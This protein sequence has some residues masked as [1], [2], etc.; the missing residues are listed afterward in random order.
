MSVTVLYDGITLAEAVDVKV[1]ELGVFLPLAAPMP[2]G[3][4]L[5]LDKAG[6]GRQSIRVRKVTE[7]GPEPG[8]YIAAEGALVFPLVEDTDAPPDLAPERTV[9][10]VS[11]SQLRREATRPEWPGPVPP[12]TLASADGDGAPIPAGAD[13]DEDTLI[14]P[15]GP[16]LLDGDTRSGR[17]RGKKGGGKR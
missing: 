14:S 5:V 2:V 16:P 1:G 4:R 15:T 13:L 8:V 10:D 6:V 7:G 12:A 11:P 17:R 3:T 9:P